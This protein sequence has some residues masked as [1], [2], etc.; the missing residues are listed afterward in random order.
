MSSFNAPAT[1]EGLITQDSSGSYVDTSVT[2][3]YWTGLDYQGAFSDETCQD[4]HLSLATE[5]GTAGCVATGWDSAG[6]CG[7]FPCSN[8]YNG[9]A[10]FFLLCAEQ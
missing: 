8:N 5:N 3:Y 7:S 1:I 10:L 2:R 9:T 4:W 6:K